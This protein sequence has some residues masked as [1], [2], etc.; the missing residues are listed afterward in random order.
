MKTLAVKAGNQI[1]ASAQLR[2]AIA[3]D[4]F[5]HTVTD[6]IRSDGQFGGAY[7]DGGNCVASWVQSNYYFLRTISPNCVASSPRSMALD[8]SDVV[9]A[10][11]SCT[12]YDA[13]GNALNV[14]GTQLLA[15]VRII[16]NQLFAAAA[17]SGGTPVSLPFNLQPS[18]SGLAFEIDFEQ[19]VAV[20]SLAP[21]TRVLEAGADA[22]AE[23]YQYVKS[24]R[25]TTKVSVGRYRMPFQATVTKQ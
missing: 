22:V 9:T 6:R 5:G 14:C 7:Y 10:P 20:A 2:D 12:V 8:F 17:L 23:L 13:A 3:G 19:S 1:P 11:A 18:F 16:A 21:N 24:G 4:G 15:D 25:S